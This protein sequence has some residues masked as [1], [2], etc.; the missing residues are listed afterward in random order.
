[1]LAGVENASKEGSLL[2]YFEGG[3]LGLLNYAQMDPTCIHAVFNYFMIYLPYILLLQ[4]M[5]E[6]FKLI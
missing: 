1:M 6:Y 4:T 5:S 2:P 3:G